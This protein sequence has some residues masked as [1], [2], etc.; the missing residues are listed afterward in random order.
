MEEKRGSGQALFL[1]LFISQLAAPD[2][3]A[4]A[5]PQ[6]GATCYR[7]TQPVVKTMGIV[8]PVPAFLSLIDFVTQLA[9]SKTVQ[10]RGLFRIQAATKTTLI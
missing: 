9:T 8:V 5:R 4:R 3:A 10:L 1:V 2:R 6:A 7:T